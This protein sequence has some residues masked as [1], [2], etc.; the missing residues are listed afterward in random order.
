MPETFLSH[1]QD[2]WPLAIIGIGLLLFVPLVLVTGIFPTNR[3]KI[4]RSQDPVTYWRWVCR[5]VVLSLACWI[6]LLGSYLLSG[7]A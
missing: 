2:N 5:F 6:V 1:L 7:R 3:G 4:F